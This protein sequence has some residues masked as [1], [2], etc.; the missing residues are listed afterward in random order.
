MKI[1]IMAAVSENGVIGSGLDIP[2]HV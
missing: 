2:W 1:S